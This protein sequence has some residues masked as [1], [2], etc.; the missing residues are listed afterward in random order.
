MQGVRIEMQNMRI[1]RESLEN[2][3][4]LK[5]KFELENSRLGEEKQ[6]LMQRITTYTREIEQFK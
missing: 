6:S 3:K 1:E 5:N 2:E 4:L